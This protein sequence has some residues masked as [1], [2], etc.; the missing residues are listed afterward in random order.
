VAKVGLQCPCVV[1]SIGQR[2][3]ASVPQHVR[4]D[5]YFNSSRISSSLQHP[6]EPSGGERRPTLTDEHKWARC[7]FP[8]KSSE[9]PHLPAGQRMCVGRARFDPTDVQE[10]VIE[11]DLLPPQVQ[12]LRRP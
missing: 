4:M 9:C 6:R 5:L 11:I 2:E 10:R 7:G 3:P 8:L 12:Q 1:P